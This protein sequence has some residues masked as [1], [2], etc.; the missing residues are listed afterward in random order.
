MI[1]SYKV[2]ER[3]RQTD[4][5][6]QTDGQTERQRDR[7]AG[8]QAD[9]QTDRD[10]ET[11]TKTNR[12]RQRQTD[13]QGNSTY[14]QYRDLLWHIK[15]ETGSL[16]H[17]SGMRRSYLRDDCLLISSS[18]CCFDF[19]FSCPFSPQ[20]CSLFQHCQSVTAALSTLLISCY[21]QQVLASSWLVHVLDNK[22]PTLTEAQCGSS[23]IVSVLDCQSVD[24]VLLI[25]LLCVDHNSLRDSRSATLKTTVTAS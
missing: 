18:P 19:Q 20:H 25:P 4:R 2:G 17:A 14:A 13:R 5:D 10:T 7:Q 16:L 1:E 3:Q 21:S 6:R 22:L 9:R 24:G 23:Y 12:Q 15:I 8:R 11:E